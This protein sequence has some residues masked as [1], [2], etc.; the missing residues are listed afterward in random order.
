MAKIKMRCGSKLRPVDVID[1]IAAQQIFLGLHIF[2]PNYQFKDVMKRIGLSRLVCF[3]YAL[4]RPS[5]VIWYDSLVLGP[6]RALLQ[7]LQVRQTY[8]FDHILLS[9]AR[10]SY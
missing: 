6:N 10:L 3:A 7:R 1:K 2:M 9:L 5:S 8:A 4:I